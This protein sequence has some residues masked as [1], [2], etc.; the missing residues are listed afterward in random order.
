MLF[1]NNFLPIITKPTRLTY[2]TATLIDHIYTN[3]FNQ[4]VIR[5]IAT[6]DISDHL[7]IFCVTDTS[8]KIQKQTRSFRDYSSF[9]EELYKNDISAT[10]WNAIYN[11]CTNLHKLTAKEIQTIPVVVDKHTPN[12]IISNIMRR[13]LMKPWITTGILKSIKTKQRMY[14]THFLSGK[15]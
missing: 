7:P 4:Q 9:N 10:D 5:G 1:S 3:S 6:I 14:K 12:K 8:I 2:H 11:E 15:R 13:K